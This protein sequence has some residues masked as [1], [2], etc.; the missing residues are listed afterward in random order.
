V[1]DSETSAD[2]LWRVYEE[3]FGYRPVNQVIK[4]VHVANGL[5]RR[6]AGVSSDHKPLADVLRQYV[7]NGGLVEERNSNRAV[8]DAYGDRFADGS[9][10]C[11]KTTPTRGPPSP[12]PC[13]EWARSESLP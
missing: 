3:E 4:P 5:Y 1:I 9:G 10:I 7:R 8:L 13:W 6:L 11:W 2:L 12:G